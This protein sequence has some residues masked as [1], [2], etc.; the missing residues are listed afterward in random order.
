VHPL[1]A[2]TLSLLA[3]TCISVLVG[4]VFLPH[5]A[6]R[7]WPDEHVSITRVLVPA[8]GIPCAALY[9]S[10]PQSGQPGWRHH[11]DLGGV[12]QM[13]V[14]GDGQRPLEPLSL[15][16]VGSSSQILLGNWD[17]SL[18]RLDTA[19]PGSPLECVGGQSD[20]GV[21]DVAASA[22]GRYAITY[23]A[24][25]VYGWDL[26]S[27]RELWQRGDLRA[28]CLGA[29]AMDDTAIVGD[30]DG[31]LY[32]L[33]LG[34]GR[35]RAVLAKLDSPAVALDVSPDG[36]RVALLTADGGVRLLDRA[37]KRTQWTIDFGWHVDSGRL[38]AFSPQGDVLV[39]TDVENP[40]GLALYSAVDGRPLRRIAGHQELVLGAAFA[41][42]GSLWSWGADAA[43]RQ[44]NPATGQALK[45]T[46][47]A[48]RS[49]ETG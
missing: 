34:T 3:V 42:D 28:S 1:A 10:I 44:W 9:W 30:F 43:I 15:T 24:F 21:M 29:S 20:G 26:A 38:I 6:R 5:E 33:D 45:T 7:L 49:S 11:L 8:K 2:A 31:T 19:A 27:D 13:L 14:P 12:E 17:G 41:A 46:R 25:R 36:E 32:E 23:N 40:L 16:R 37:T 18:Y 48:P 47:L 39:T 4:L 35:T 22:D